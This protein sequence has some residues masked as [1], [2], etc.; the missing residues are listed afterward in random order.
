MAQSKIQISEVI[1]TKTISVSAHEMGIGYAEL[2]TTRRLHPSY[3]SSKARWVNPWRDYQK[4][5][6]LQK[7]AT[8]PPTGRI[9][10]CNLQKPKQKPKGQVEQNQRLG[11]QISPQ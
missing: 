7:W 11:Y 8:W 9:N 4:N 3:L 2:L 6:T 1:T 5:N 10:F